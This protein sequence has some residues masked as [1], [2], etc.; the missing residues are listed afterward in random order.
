MPVMDSGLDSRRNRPHSRTT[1]F[2]TDRRLQRCQSSFV[3]AGLTNAS[4]QTVKIHVYDME[5]GGYRFVPPLGTSIF[6][7]TASG[8]PWIFLRVLSPSHVGTYMYPLPTPRAW[9]HL[10][11]ARQ[12]PRADPVLGQRA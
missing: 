2:S 1:A 12:I 4:R 5:L 8:R 11:S 3:S 10:P 7:I 9:F 6:V